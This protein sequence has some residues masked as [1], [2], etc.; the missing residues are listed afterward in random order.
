VPVN[1][2]PVE[3]FQATPNNNITE[4]VNGNNQQIPDQNLM[5]QIAPSN[6]FFVM[7]NSMPFLW[8]PVDPGFESMIELFPDSWPL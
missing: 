2:A 7:D 8:D 6:E 5:G 1:S 4:N 3:T